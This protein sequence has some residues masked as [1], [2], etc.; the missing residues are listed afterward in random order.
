MGAPRTY[1]RRALTVLAVLLAVVA[2]GA[3]DE[4]GASVSRFE[5]AAP[6]GQEL[7][8]IAIRPAGAGERPPLL[9]LLHGRTDTLRGPRSWLSDEL[10][11]ALDRLGAGAPA[12]LLVNGGRSSYYH[13]R[14]SGKWARY[15]L[16]RVL[17]EGLERLGADPR[18]VAIGGISMGG[19]GALH[20]A[21]KR[22]FCAVGGHSPALWRSAGETAPG[23]FDDAAG[24]DRV[25]VFTHLPRTRPVWLDVGRRDP[26]RSATVALARRMGV[27]VR[28]WA[29]GH[30][31]A[32][33]RRH[34]G[35]YVRFYARALKRC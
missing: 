10:F 27:R 21:R 5:I 17:P 18:R 7:E 28:V 4:R 16:R 19:F 35:A 1:R 23:A 24:F 20:L 12:V 9:I 32:Y 29:G 6:G 31:G 25:N 2:I 8:Q 11:A 33:W 13:D 3:A 14:R 26:F 22:R 30:D 34:V 15:V